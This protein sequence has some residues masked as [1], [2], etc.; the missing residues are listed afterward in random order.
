MRKIAIFGGSF[1]PIH[2]GHIQLATLAKETA[3]LDEVWFLPCHLS[4]HKTASPPLADSL[5]AKCMEIAISQL[6]WA[7]IE[8]SEIE[9]EGISFSYQTME[10][11]QSQHPGNQWFWI[12]GGDQ[13]E[14]LPRWQK[15][16]KLASQVEFLV[17]ARNGKEILPRQ[18]YRMR[19]IPGEHPAS[20]SEIRKALLQKQRSIPHLNPAVEEILR[21]F[22][23]SK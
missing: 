5:R 12:L 16:E 17:L 8:R 3:Q 9:R 14:A 1:D 7:R 6:P 19:S 15:P 13:W 18:G 21:E 2:D 22:Y 10:L 20:S 4:P 11:L 23:Q